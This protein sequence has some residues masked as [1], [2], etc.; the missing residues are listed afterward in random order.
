MKNLD[1]MPP[2]KG[3]SDREL[4]TRDFL[5]A[6]R[7]QRLLQTEA[8]DLTFLTDEER[9]ASLRDTLA[10]RP[11]GP[12]WVFAYGSLIWNPLIKA[13][14]RRVAR[15]EGWHRSFCLSDVAG[16]GSQQFPGLILALE[17]GGACDGVAYRIDE[18]HLTH[19]LEILWR[20]EMVAGAYKP[21]WV[22][23]SDR[24]ES[25]LECALTF[26]A[27]P[28]HTQYKR[29]LDRG[30]IIRRLATGSGLLGSA[31]DYLFAT[32]KGLRL[33]NLSDPEIESIASQVAMEQ[34]LAKR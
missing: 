6:G 3:L 16:R 32:L 7:L 33:N 29:G 20:R 18:E 22:G 1:E 25:R 8:P 28:A 4:L 9:K 21:R 31:A 13:V 26:T 5:E 30:E 19:E 17:P 15:V 27:D 34:E 24:Y 23:M 2:E 11:K 14:E 12:V 10:Q